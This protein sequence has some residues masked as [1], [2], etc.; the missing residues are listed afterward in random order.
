MS[1]PCVG[2]CG[3]IFWLENPVFDE[4]YIHEPIVKILE[5]HVKVLSKKDQEALEEDIL[6]SPPANAEA[7]VPSLVQE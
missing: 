5:E 4:S 1:V 2:R 6:N 3:T 7:D